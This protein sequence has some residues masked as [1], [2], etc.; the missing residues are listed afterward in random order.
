MF[1]TLWRDLSVIRMSRFWPHTAYEEDQ[2]YG[3]SILWAHILTRVPPTAAV[4]GATTAVGGLTLRKLKILAPKALPSSFTT[5]LLRSIG[6]ST[7]YTTGVVAIATALKMHGREEIEWQE[8]SWRLLEN[9]GQVECDDFMYGGMALGLLGGVG[10]KLPWQ[11]RLGG[12]GAGS[13][14]GVMTYMGWRY[15][16]KNGKREEDESV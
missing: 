9:K 5:T 12:L 16:V 6:V 1:G 11:V 10:K 4:L 7:V 3:K 13:L 15:G 8:R 2:P 14:M